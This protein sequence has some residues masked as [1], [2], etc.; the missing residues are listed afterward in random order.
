[1]M[2]YSLAQ[3][4]PATLSVRDARDAYLA[5]NGFT[6]EDYDADHTPVNVWGVW[7]KFPNP[8]S[9]KLALRYHDLH[10][11]MT[12]YGTDLTGEIESSASELRRGIRGFGPF[13]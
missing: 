1:M 9:R 6:I 7:F 12:G 3:P 2:V 10:H 13:I 4:L 8:P 11:I 5:E